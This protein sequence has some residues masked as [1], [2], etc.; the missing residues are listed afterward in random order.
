[1]QTN[2]TGKLIEI[3]LAED[4]PGDARLAIEALKD[5]KLANHVNVVQDGVEAM[6]SCEKAG[7]IC[8]CAPPGP[9]MLK[10][11]KT[12][13]SETTL[14]LSSMEWKRWNS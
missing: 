2:E 13:R 8:A 5:A 4:N 9:I 7:P 6:D 10:P 14:I 11:L 3:L 1:M 12:P